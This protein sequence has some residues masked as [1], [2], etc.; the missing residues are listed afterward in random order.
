MYPSPA[1]LYRP[2]IPAQPVQHNSHP[3]SAPPPSASSYPYPQHN[4]QS[5]PP[6]SGHPGQAM[7]YTMGAIPPGATNQPNTNLNGPPSVRF[8]DRFLAQQDWCFPCLDQWH[9]WFAQR[10]NSCQSIYRRA[11]DVISAKWRKSTDELQ[12]WVSSRC[13]AFVR[14]SRPRESMSF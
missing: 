5:M 3:S 8:R 10:E 9:G 14:W 13:V 7:P 1:S 11:A 12:S 4:H 6:T 2:Q